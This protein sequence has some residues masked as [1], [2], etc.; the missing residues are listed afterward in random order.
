MCGDKYIL[1]IHA[2]L[3]H[4]QMP[5]QCCIRCVLCSL[6]TLEVP[7]DLSEV[8]SKCT[9]T[10]FSSFTL[11]HLAR[12]WTEESMGNHVHGP[13]HRSSKCHD[14]VVPALCITL[15]VPLYRCSEARSG[16]TLKIYVLY[17]L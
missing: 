10:V 13:Q 6:F 14:T 15:A 4:N 7:G 1:L 11:G 16:D 9:A 3:V 17:V 2:H 8:A 12:P 5:S